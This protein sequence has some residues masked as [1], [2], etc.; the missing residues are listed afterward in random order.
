MNIMI[1]CPT[2]VS[3]APITVSHVLIL[4]YV[5]HVL[6]HTTLIKQQMH[7]SHVYL[8]VQSA[9][10]QLPAQPAKMDSILTQMDNA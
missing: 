3:L 1:I 2:P 10:I 4:Q 9:L 8:V 6:P 5:L 7:V